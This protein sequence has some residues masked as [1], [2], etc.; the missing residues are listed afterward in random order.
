MSHLRLFL[1][2]RI[3]II[4]KN[5]DIEGKCYNRQDL[6]H[7]SADGNKRLKRKESQM[8]GHQRQKEQSRQM[9]EKAL[10]ALMKE[11]NYSQITI[12]ELV[13]RADVARRT[14]YRLYEKK[15]DIIRNYFERLCMDYREQNGKL[16]SYDIQRIA[17]D[18]FTF[19]YQYREFLLLLYG[20]GLDDM[21]YYGINRTSMEVIKGRIGDSRLQNAPDLAYFAD[22]T[23]GGFISLLFRWITDG[24]K[25]PPETYAESVSMS[26]LRFIRPAK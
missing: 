18:Y 16:D 4:R 23:A 15:E 5:Q 20:S 24:M 21:L 2:Y 17:G 14:F 3:L 19:W 12:S 22:Y 25:E 6:C 9:I 10:F 8:D 1:S 13:K 7:I 11:K 26:L